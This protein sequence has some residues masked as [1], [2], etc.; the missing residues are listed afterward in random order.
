MT[1][2]SL[3]GGVIGY[4]RRRFPAVLTKGTN[5]PR[6]MDPVADPRPTLPRLPDLN[7][8]RTAFAHMSDADLRRAWWLFTVI[9]NKTV[10][11]VGAALTNAALWLHLPVKGAIKATIFRQFCGGETMEESLLTAQRLAVKGI[12]SILDY[13]V[14]GQED[15]DTLDHTT[16]EIIGTIRQAKEHAFVPFC[17]FKPSGISPVALL[18]AMSEGRTLNDEDRREWTRVQERFERICSSAHEAGVPVLVDA[19]ESWMQAAIDELAERAMA[20]YNRDRAIVFN[21]VQLYRHDRL[22]YLRAAYARAVEGGYRFGVKLVRGAYMEKERAHASE[23]GTTDPIQPDKAASDR[24]YDAALRFAIDHIDRLSVMAGTHNE[25]SSLLF[26]R[27]V[28]EH[29]LA[30]NDRRIW[31]AQLLGMSDHISYNLAAAGFNVAK[32]VPYGPVREVMPYLL[33][34]AAENTSARGQSGRE[35]SLINAERK[36][37]KMQ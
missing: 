28:D 22:A 4:F 33:R 6:T 34:R 10:S 19:E 36:R 15:D 13:S 26:A 2:V 12:G 29:G 11:D 16:E 20:R 1:K 32:Y 24:D 37:R 18:E 27:L 31:S 35:L 23:K 8:T 21:T 5:S 9:G 30:R 3:R 25:A 14:E 7:D 17:V